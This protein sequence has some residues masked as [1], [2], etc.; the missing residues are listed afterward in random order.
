MTLKGQTKPNCG[1]GQSA[2]AAAKVSFK[3]T[4]LQLIKRIND[5]V[6]ISAQQDISKIK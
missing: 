1:S 5:I 6:K 3:T 4:L 2:A